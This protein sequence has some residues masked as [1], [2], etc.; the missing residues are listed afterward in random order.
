[1]KLIDTE[2]YDNFVSPNSEEDSLWPQEST[3]A[4]QID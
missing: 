2:F 3:K 1:M 4:F